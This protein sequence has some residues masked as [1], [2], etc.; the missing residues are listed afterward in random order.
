MMMMIGGGEE[1]QLE[2]FPS[3]AFGFEQIHEEYS[4]AAQVNLDTV[5]FIDWPGV[6]SQ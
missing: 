6:G 3:T 4:A 2:E 5:Q 1:K